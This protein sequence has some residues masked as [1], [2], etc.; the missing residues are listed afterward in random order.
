MTA[1]DSVYRRYLRALMK[2][3]ADAHLATRPGAGRF[4]F[5]IDNINLLSS[6]SAEVHTCIFDSLVVYDTG[7]SDQVGDDIVFDDD[8]ISGHTAWLVIVHDD[9]WKWSEA[10]ATDTKY[11]E[12]I[13]GFGS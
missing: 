4:R 6:F 7:R 11:G 9:K 12:D 10:T 5:R 1:P 2:T 13:C 3:R 8:V